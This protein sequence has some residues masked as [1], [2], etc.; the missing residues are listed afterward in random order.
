[1]KNNAFTLV[2]L[3]LVITILGILSTV[4]IPRIGSIITDS[5]IRATQAEMRSLKTA[6]TGNPEVT[7]T[8]RFLYKGYLGDVG[9]LPTPANGLSCLAGNN[10]GEPAWDKWNGKG[11]NGPY[12]EASNNDYLSDAWGISYVYTR[13]SATSGMITSYGSDRVSGGGDDI[14][15]S[16]GY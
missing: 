10:D 16:F 2:E 7:G 12:I 11:W 3:V 14:I 5:R 6:L 8:G 9:H 4:A 1:M 15:I 13:L